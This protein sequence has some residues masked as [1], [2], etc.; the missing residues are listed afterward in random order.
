MLVR[1]NLACRVASR[2]PPR[3]R[4]PKVGC[5]LAIA[6]RLPVAGATTR[7]SAAWRTGHSATVAAA[8]AVGLVRWVTSHERRVIHMVPDE[9]G[10]LAIARFVGRGLRWYQTRPT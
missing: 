3:R 5:L 2:A 8:L 9:P 10:Q 4:R 7:R 1:W 6:E